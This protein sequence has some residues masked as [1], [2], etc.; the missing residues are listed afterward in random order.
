[1]KIE[2]HV[3]R[4]RKWWRCDE[5]NSELEWRKSNEHIGRKLD[6]SL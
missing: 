3:S 5:M 4:R 2:L 1:V 6:N